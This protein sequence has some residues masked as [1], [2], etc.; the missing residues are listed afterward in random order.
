MLRPSGERAKRRG[1]L[2]TGTP[3]EVIKRG[4]IDQRS[5]LYAAGC[6]AFEALMGANC[7]RG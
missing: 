7:G 2:P 5:D 4:A 1:R 3:P 6:L